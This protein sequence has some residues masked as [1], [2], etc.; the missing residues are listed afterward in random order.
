MI[1]AAIVLGFAVVLFGLPAPVAA[2]QTSYAGAIHAGRCGDLAG[3]VADL[4]DAV[5]ASGERSGHAEALPAANAFSTVPVSLDA[6]VANDHAIVVERTGDHRVVACG[7]IGG[8]PMDDGA[9]I[10]GLRGASD[11]AIAGVAYVAPG[12]DPAQTDASVFFV[13]PLEEGALESPAQVGD[14]DD[15]LSG[16]APA[17]SPI[18]SDDERFASGGLGLSL[19]DWQSLH[20]PG[21]DPPG[22][23]GLSYEDGQFDALA[24]DD[25]NIRWLEVRFNV[26]VSFDDARLLAANYAP[27]DAQLIG[28]YVAEFGLPVDLYFSESLA[29]RFPDA[30]D[31]PEAEPGQFIVIYGQF[32]P[33]EGTGDVTTLVMALGN[34]P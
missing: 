30:D 13:L 20:G 22:S 31:W 6:L 33:P 1:R 14:G 25:G 34:A 8:F 29:A 17:D 28:T 3:V 5:I 16:V 12:T 7:E 24:F 21:A 9:L 23:L 19:V 15:P 18:A 27:P 2:Q 11:P 26:G 4:N 10:L 32:G